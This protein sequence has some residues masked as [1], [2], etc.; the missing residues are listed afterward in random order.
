MKTLTLLLPD[1]FD[2]SDVCLAFDSLA[3]YYRLEI[4]RY[5]S[6]RY[7]QTEEV[8]QSRAHF[9]RKAV[10]LQEILTQFSPDH[11]MSEGAQAERSD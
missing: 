9:K 6:D 7:I 3:F 1:G 8:L 10:L 2:V 11:K 5:Q 4:E